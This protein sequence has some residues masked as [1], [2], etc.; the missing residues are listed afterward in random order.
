MFASKGRL[1]T[2]L[3]R[4][5][6]RMLGLP[7]QSPPRWYRDRLREELYERR[8]ATTHWG[9]VSETSDVLFSISRALYDGVP[10][11]QLPALSRHIPAY[12]YMVAKYTL[13]WKFYRV[14]GGM[15]HAPCRESIREVINPDRDHKLLEVALRH[16]I[17]PVSF[18]L[19]AKRL[20][21]F[22]PLLP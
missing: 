15:C 13:R 12:M 2:L 16:D 18:K 9:K 21:R 17:D 1:S 7:R 4:R 11:R 22:W 10:T 8:S 6:H 5:W 3:L 20:R 14:A 19:A